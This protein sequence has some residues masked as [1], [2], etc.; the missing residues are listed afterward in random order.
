LIFFSAGADRESV[1]QDTFEALEES[2]R[3][4]V[5]FPAIEAFHV[6]GAQPQ[7]EVPAAIADACRRSFESDHAPRIAARLS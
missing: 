2:H 4:V 3:S 7:E 1:T 6:D 5:S